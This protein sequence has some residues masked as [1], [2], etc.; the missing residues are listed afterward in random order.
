VRNLNSWVKAS[1]LRRSFSVL[2]GLIGISAL[3]PEASAGDH[4]KPVQLVPYPT[5]F[6]YAPVATYPGGY[7]N[8]NAVYANAPNAGYYP[9]SPAQATTIIYGNA[10][11]TVAS[12]GMAP[13]GNGLVASGNGA[14]F[15]GSPVRV[16]NSRLTAEGLNDVYEDLKSEFKS[17]QSEKSV[18]RRAR[19]IAAAKDLY[20]E[21]LTASL[22]DAVVSSTDDLKDPELQ[23]ING[24]VD[25]VVKSDS[26]NSSSNTNNGIYGTY[27]TYGSG[28]APVSGPAPVGP[29]VQPAPQPPLYYYYYPVGPVKK[30]FYKH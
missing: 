30:H 4:K 2:L 18:T 5:T 26:Q 8:G 24:L 14:G 15:A 16:A 10:P 27:G 1:R 3:S 7:V 29:F 11:Q 22:G 28:L 9:A 6:G 13:Y 20:V 17:L 21:V 23:E 12:Y 25:L 19:L